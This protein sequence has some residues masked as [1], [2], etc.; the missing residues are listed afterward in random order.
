MGRGLIHIAAAL[1]LTLHAF[2]AW[3]QQGVEQKLERMAAEQV[4]HLCPDCTVRVETRWLPDRLAGSDTSEISGLRL[5]AS[6]LP[7]G[8]LTAEAEL[9]S[10]E[11]STAQLQL[12]VSVRRQVAVAARRI[13]AGEK[14]TAEIVRQ[15]TMDLTRLRELPADLPDALEGREAARLIQEGSVILRSDLRRPAAVEP[16]DPV[17]MIYR[18][19][20]MEIHLSCTARQARADGQSVRL[21]CSETG[22]DYIGTLINSSKARWEKTL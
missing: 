7:R 4:A 20:G 12:H 1:L 14:I 16:G 6:E 22:K 19:G 15:R 2:P 17:T 18:S 11:N 9:E 5:P 13:G 21:H 10:E 3:A 8:Y